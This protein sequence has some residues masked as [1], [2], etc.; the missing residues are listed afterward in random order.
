MV[1]LRRPRQESLLKD[2][3]AQFGTLLEHPHPGLALVAAKRQAETA[4]LLAKQAMLQARAADHA[5]ARFLATMS[6]ELRTPL[7]AIIGF[8]EI[9]KLDGARVRERYPEYA[10]YIHEAGV[11]LL[12]IINGILDLARIEAGKVDLHEELVPLGD[13]VEA[14]LRT[15]CPLAEKKS[16]AIECALESPSPLVSVD[17]TKIKQVFLNLLSNAIKFTPPGGCVTIGTRRNGN[18]DL[19][20]RI[21]DSGVGIPAGQ[22]TRVLE[23]FEQVES[24]LTRKTDGTGLGLPIAKGLMALHG[25]ELIIDSKPGG[26]TAVDVRLP[27][28]RIRSAAAATC[29]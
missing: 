16:I 12:E 23:P 6:H 9:I 25:G 21:A 10:G 2:F 18:G 5:K 20:I 3:C 28:S 15:L 8:S 19:V 29:G 27:S 1:T 24:P 7:N 26:G 11:F 13:I 17:P 14:S 22:L 4:A